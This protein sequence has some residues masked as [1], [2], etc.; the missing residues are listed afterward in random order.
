[1][2]GLPRKSNIFLA[3]SVIRNVP[4]VQYATVISKVE[5]I[6]LDFWLLIVFGADNKRVHGPAQVLQ[7]FPLLLRNGSRLSVYQEASYR[8]LQE[9]VIPTELCLL[10]LHRHF[11][12]LALISGTAMSHLMRVLEEEKLGVPSAL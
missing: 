3:R 12:T 10:L 6:V 7:L 8:Q 2:Q 1:M 11:F 5:L 9:V 4:K